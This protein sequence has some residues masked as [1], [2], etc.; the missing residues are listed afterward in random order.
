MDAVLQKSLTL[1]SISPLTAVSGNSRSMTEAKTPF[2]H[3]HNNKKQ[4]QI[5]KNKGMNTSRNKNKYYSNSRLNES[6]EVKGRMKMQTSLLLCFVLLNICSY[7]FPSP[8]LALG[9]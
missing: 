3:R 5:V 9:P 2:H 8:L 1:S 6:A 7:W 4:I